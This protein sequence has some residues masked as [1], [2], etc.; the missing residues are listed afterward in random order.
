MTTFKDRFKESFT[1]RVVMALVYHYTK[2]ISQKDKNHT[3]SLILKASLLFCTIVNLK[4]NKIRSL[5]MA[6]QKK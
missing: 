4:I 1:Y 3:T 2:Q 6:K 5:K